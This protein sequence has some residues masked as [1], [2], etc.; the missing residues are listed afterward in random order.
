MYDDKEQKNYI[1]APQKN[2]RESQFWRERQLSPLRGSYLPQSAAAKRKTPIVSVLAPCQYTVTA[3]CDVGEVAP[4]M[5]E[6]T[7][8]AVVE[9][10]T[11]WYC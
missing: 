8:Q 5:L 1:L 10:N 11:H 4:I 2:W 3:R 9:C 6:A 7:V